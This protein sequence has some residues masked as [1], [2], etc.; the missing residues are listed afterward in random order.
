MGDYLRY[1]LHNCDIQ[2]DR[3]YF[4][5]HDLFPLAFVEVKVSKTGLDY[6]LLDLVKNT[7]YVVPELRIVKIITT[8]ISAVTIFAFV[9]LTNSPRG[10]IPEFPPEC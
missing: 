3:L 9:A 5:I 10:W 7:D 2:S 8:D 1:E 4:F 6:V